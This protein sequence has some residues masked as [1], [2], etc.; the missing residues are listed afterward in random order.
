MARESGRA[1]V[2]LVRDAVAGYVDEVAGTRDTLNSRYD[3]IN[4]ETAVGSC[5]R[6]YYSIYQPPM[7]IGG[8]AT[9]LGLTNKLANYGYRGIPRLP[10][11]AGA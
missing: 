10:S 9:S 11:G 2:E 7:I 5:S 4:L 1:A 3:D 8:S 6:I